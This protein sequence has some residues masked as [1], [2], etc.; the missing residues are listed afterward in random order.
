MLCVLYV[1]A[2]GTCSKYPRTTHATTVALATW[3]LQNPEPFHEYDA[4]KWHCHHFATF[5]C[6]TWLSVADLEEAKMKKA[7]TAALLQESSNACDSQTEGVLPNVRL[8][9]RIL[10][11]PVALALD[12]V[13]AKVLKTPAEKEQ[14]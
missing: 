1:L 3:L 9:T 2:A 12:L 5:C 14:D 6:T 4:A 13:G 7:L 10:I 11:S 8:A